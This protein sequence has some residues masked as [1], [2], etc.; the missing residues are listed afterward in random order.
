VALVLAICGHAQASASLT[1]LL[2]SAAQ[3][4]DWLVAT[5]RE[6]HQYPELMFHVGIAVAV[7]GC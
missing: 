2:D 4:E 1:S 6:L 5:R 7:V 3:I